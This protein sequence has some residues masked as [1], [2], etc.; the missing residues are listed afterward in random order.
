MIQVIE[1]FIEYL[2]EWEEKPEKE[3]L[4]NTTHKSM[5]IS[6]KGVLELVMF[7]GTVGF[8]YLMLKH[9]K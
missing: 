8:E 3:R 2:Q 7:L 5:L 4:S 6:L 1:G 9:I